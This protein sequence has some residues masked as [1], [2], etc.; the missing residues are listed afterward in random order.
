MLARRRYFKLLRRQTVNNPPGIPHNAPAL[1][2]RRNRVLRAIKNSGTMIA[3]A[4]AAV[5]ATG[6]SHEPR[7]SKD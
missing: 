2:R 7:H 5:P 3:P 4:P 1:V 6:G